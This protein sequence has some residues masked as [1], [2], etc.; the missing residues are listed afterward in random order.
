MGPLIG[1]TLQLHPAL[2]LTAF[3]ATAVVFACFSGA[4]MLSRRR[5]WLYLSGAPLHAQ[6]SP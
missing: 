1:A 3:M 2:L 6:C 4:A 5:S